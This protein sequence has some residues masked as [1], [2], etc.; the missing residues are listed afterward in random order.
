MENRKH[1]HLL[2]KDKNKRKTKRAKPNEKEKEASEETIHI[3]DIPPEV[4]L[5]IVQLLTVHDQFKVTSVSKLFY[6]LIRELWQLRL[7]QHYPLPR[8]NPEQEPQDQTQ[9]VDHLP[10]LYEKLKNDLER[11][12][13]TLSGSVRRV[14]GHPREKIETLFYYLNQN[15]LESLKIAFP[16]Y[17]HLEVAFDCYFMPG[18]IPQE[19]LK[20]VF[21]NVPKRLLV[22][23]H[24]QEGLNYLYQLVSNETV[25]SDQP[26][27]FVFASSILRAILFNQSG[28]TWRALGKRGSDLNKAYSQS[29]SDHDTQPALALSGDDCVDIPLCLAITMDNLVQ[30]KHLTELGAALEVSV[31]VKFTTSQHETFN[32]MTYNLVGF[33]AHHQRH[34]IVLYLLKKLEGK[35]DITA[36]CETIYLGSDFNALECFLE[37]GIAIDFRTLKEKHPNTWDGFIRS[38]VEKNR[39]SLLKKIQELLTS[40]PSSLLLGPAKE[41]DHVLYIAADRGYLELFRFLQDR[42]KDQI[43]FQEL[44]NA[45]RQNGAARVLEIFLICGLDIDF[46]FVNKKT[47]H[48]VWWKELVANAVGSNCEW[49]LEKIL[50]IS[51]VGINTNPSKSAVGFK[52]RRF[53]WIHLAAEYGH[54]EAVRLLVK[55]GAKLDRKDSDH[56][57]VKHGTRFK[58][59]V[60]EGDTP[61]KLSINNGHAEI[62]HYLFE[63]LQEKNQSPQFNIQEKE[64]MIKNALLNEHTEVL[65]FLLHYI[66]PEKNLESLLVDAA[67]NDKLEIVKWLIE[68]K[69]VKCNARVPNKKPRSA[70]AAAVEHGHDVTVHYLLRLQVEVRNEAWRAA[71]SYFKINPQTDEEDAKKMIR[72]LNHFTKKYADED[73]AIEE[74]TKTQSI[75]SSATLFYHPPV[76]LTPDPNEPNCTIS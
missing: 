56:L 64:E 10:S 14:Q 19:S 16:T 11:S 47:P 59:E 15:D 46:S 70:L 25:H 39:I 52:K 6:A 63:Q 51:T 71:Y 68:K 7:E 72:L 75:S 49:L 2:D 31:Q 66:Y 48:T 9:T 76:Q 4:L 55:H 5:L 8:K 42:F 22:R 40:L 29:H 30:V 60:H 53:Y 35:I 20:Y 61:L 1:L 17:S 41:T 37:C 38:A 73:R 58:T 26:F 28:K 69:Q 24:Y 23:P 32:Y 18:K 65:E 21:G 62:A 12:P 44:G 45:A 54:I 43:N 57:F 27:P 74:L 34:S 67:K 33:A 50:S 3:I 13:V 36:T